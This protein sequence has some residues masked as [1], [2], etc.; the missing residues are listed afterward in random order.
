[1]GGRKRP[2]HHRSRDTHLATPCKVAPSH[3]MPCA[4]AIPPSAPTAPTTKGGARQ[5]VSSTSPTGAIA[6]SVGVLTEPVTRGLQSAAASRPTPAADCCVSAG[7]PELFP[8]HRPK[9]TL[10][11]IKLNCC[12]VGPGKQVSM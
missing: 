5:T 4:N 1:T 11:P 7:C 8:Q 6:K 12:D 10:H 3:D 2:F 9:Q